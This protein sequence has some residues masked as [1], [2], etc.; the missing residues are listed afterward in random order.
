MIG[1]PPER[2][3]L[4]PAG[5]LTLPESASDR[6]RVSRLRASGQAVHLGPGIYVV[7]GS[8][9]PERLVY[10]HYQ[11]IV[12]RFWPGAVLCDRTGIANGQPD[13]GYLFVC[14]PEL[15]RQTDLE[16]PGLV[17]SPRVGPAPLPGDMS[18][19]HGL[20][21]AGPVRLL[22]ENVP[23]RGRPSVHRPSRQAGWAAL[24]DRIDQEATTGGAGRIQ[25]MLNQLDLIAGSFSPFSVREIRRRLVEVLGTTS[26][27]VPQSER[28]AARLS[29]EPFDQQRLDL[30]SSLLV[31]LSARA[32]TARPA[33][34]GTDRWKWEPFFEAYFSNF[35]EG[36]EFGV[37]EARRIAIDGEVPAARPQDAHDVSATFL[38]VSDPDM[39]SETATSQDEFIELLRH[40]HAS[41]M[42]ARP[43]KRPGQFKEAQN[44]A[45]G[46]AFAN[47]KLVLGTLRRGFDLVASVLDPFQ[48]AAAMMAL[49]TEVH[50]FDDGNGRLARIMSNAE[51]SAAGEVRIVIPTIYRNDYIAGLAG[52]SNRSGRGQA[53]V[54]VLDFAQRWTAQIDWRTFESAHEELTAA[55]AYMDAAVAERSGYRLRLNN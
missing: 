4:S 42:A 37:E 43:D 26:G 30:V 38:I 18:I 22:L 23:T 41:L 35:I 27:V 40:R 2:A 15:T 24:E 50:P 7:G 14:Q 51:L 16:L 17:I 48:R 29:G 36:T 53:L 25:A 28:Y 32:S 33:V 8:L 11:E 6:R 13:H 54:A 47:P 45:G 31:T 3:E 20:H 5:V 19:P 21:L 46:Y 10:E 44:Y 34:G 55:S 1:T 52:M 9:P 12:A 39:A 49:L